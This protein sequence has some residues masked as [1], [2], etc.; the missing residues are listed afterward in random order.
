VD[1]SGER[2]GSEDASAGAIGELERGD[3]FSDGRG[4]RGR[5]RDL[6]SPLGCGGRLLLRGLLL[7]G[8][9]H[10]GGEGRRR[11]RADEEESGRTERDDSAAHLHQTRIVGM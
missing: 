10:H 7:A 8:V 6:G 9:R 2:V 5:G 4:G 11:R 1:I 3:G